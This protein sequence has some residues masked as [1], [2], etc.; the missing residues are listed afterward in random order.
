MK[1]LKF[2]IETYPEAARHLNNSGDLPI[3]YAALWRSP[4]FCRVLIEA[5]PGSE[6]MT[7]KSQG[8]LPLHLACARN[9]FD[10]V[11]QIFWLYPD[12]MNHATIGGVYPI[13]GAICN[14]SARDDPMTAAE[15]VQFL[16]DRDANVSVK[17]QSFQETSLIQYVCEQEYND[18]NIE[19]GIQIIKAIYDAHPEAIED[20]DF[21]SDIDSFDQQ[22]Q[23]LIN[24]ELVY[25]R[26]AKD[27]RLM[28]TPDD[29]RQLPLHKALQNNV[30]LGSIKLL[31]KGNPSAL[32]YP[33]DSGVIPLHLACQHHDCATVVQY[34]LD[35]DERTLRAV[36]CDNNTALHYACLGAKYDTIA[37]LLEK[38]DALSV[39]KKNAQNMLPI[40]LL[41]ESAAVLDRESIEYTGSIFRLLKA[42]PEMIMNGSMKQQITSGEGPSQNG[43]KRKYGDTT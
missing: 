32:G 10:T 5:Y 28:N 25:A 31:V 38:Y 19:A 9:S 36:D 11:E 30:R 29:N 35:L 12:A 34:L 7:E 20:D 18:S 23:A 40:E 43:K 14:M 26:Q 2:L 4:E 15:T 39:S 3:H 37:L 16:L 27:L 21:A 13:H 33:D 17:L 8:V 1:I 41:W 6:R 42:Y 22:V 24:S